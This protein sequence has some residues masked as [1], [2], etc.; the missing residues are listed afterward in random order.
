MLQ[1]RLASVPIIAAL[2]AVAPAPAAAPAAVDLKVIKGDEV[3]AALRPA[4]GRARLIHLWATWCVPCVA[5]WPVLARRLRELDGRPLDVVVISIDD[6][7]QEA[8]AEKV[9]GKLEGVPGTLLLAPPGEA[10]P[11]VKGIDPVWDGAI[12]T[13]Y[14][15]DADGRVVLAER[16]ATRFDELDGALDRVAPAKKGKKKP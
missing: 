11:A 13:T 2:L 4:P 16:G 6:A 14:L 5:E 3:K 8:A 10:M 15:L 7:A 9:L 12:P 1:L